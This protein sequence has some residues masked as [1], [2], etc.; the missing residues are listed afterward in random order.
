MY[1]QHFYVIIATAYYGHDHCWI[2]K[3]IHVFFGELLSLPVA[4]RLPTSWP[5]NYVWCMYVAQHSRGVY[6]VYQNINISTMSLMNTLP[7]IYNII[8][9][10]SKNITRR[11]LKQNDEDTQSNNMFIFVQIWQGNKEMGVELGKS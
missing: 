3:V 1:I 10:W 7:W 2:E 5:I 9:V 6:I 8:S 11:N 4:W